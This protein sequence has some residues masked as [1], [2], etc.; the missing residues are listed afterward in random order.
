MLQIHLILTEVLAMKSLTSD[1]ETESNIS[2]PHKIS[3]RN[4]Y[5]KNKKRIKREKKMNG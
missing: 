3:K 5:N 4:K 2:L 1:T